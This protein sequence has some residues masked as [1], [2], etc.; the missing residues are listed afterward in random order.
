MPRIRTITRDDAGVDA[1]VAAIVEQG[2][3]A[4]KGWIHSLFLARADWDDL[5]RSWRNRMDF[6]PDP[7]G[8]ETIRSTV[9]LLAQLEALYGRILVD[10]DD[11]AAMV[12]TVCTLRRVPCRLTV[13]STK[14]DGYV[15][16]I[17]AQVPDRHNPGSFVPFDPLFTKD[18]G[19]AFPSVRTRNY[20]V[21]P[22]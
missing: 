8:T 20:F 17:Y 21:S 22:L 19:D 14:H 11:V 7:Q 10:C 16:H 5:F 2:R 9:N 12:V 3:N 6:K 13:S 4:A 18:F 1:T 15:E